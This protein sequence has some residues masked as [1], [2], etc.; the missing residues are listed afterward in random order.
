MN[1]GSGT[2]TDETVPR[3]PSRLASTT[4]LALGDLDGDGDLDLFVGNSHLGEQNHMYLNDGTGTFTD[5]TAN[6][7]PTRDDWTS[8][9]ALGDVDGDGDLDLVVGNAIGRDAL[10]F[11]LLRQLHAPIVL[12]LGRDYQ[13]DV[14]ARYGPARVSDLAMPFFSGSTANI[15]LSSWGVLRLDPVSMMPLPTFAVPRS[16]GV[17]SLVIP[18]PNLPA[19]VGGLIHTQVLLVQNPTQIVLTNRSQD[20][21]LR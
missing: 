6:R 7:V 5:V 14:H 11:N 18:M 3:M 10:Y 9:L 17:A 16:T 20:I 13:L 4:S 12:Q 21:I 19:L 2:F 1:D 8:S 15:P